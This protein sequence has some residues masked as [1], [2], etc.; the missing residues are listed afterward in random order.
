MSNETQITDEQHPVNAAEPSGGAAIPVSISFD[1]IK[2]KISNVFYGADTNTVIVTA[3]K[4]YLY[5]LTEGQ[6]ITETAREKCDSEVYRPLKN[7]YV[8]IGMTMKRSG[9]D[10][11]SA[12]SSFGIEVK[13]V[14]Y[15]SGLHKLSAIDISGLTASD[16]M[17]FS[18]SGVAV[19]G[20]GNLIAFATD[21]GLYVYNVRTSE[22]STVIDC[23]TADTGTRKGI[24]SVEQVTFMK[25]EKTLVFS[26]QSFDVPAIEGNRS[27]DTVGTVGIDGSNLVNAKVTNSRKL[28]LHGFV[29]EESK[30][31]AFGSADSGYYAVTELGSGKLYVRVYDA[32]SEKLV[33]EKE[34]KEDSRH[35]ER[36]PVVRILDKSKTLIVL[37]GNRQDDIDTIVLS[38]Q[39]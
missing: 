15:D 25:D 17:I 9:G 33:H 14:F 4:L 28:A 38:E 36:D 6:V 3:D 30:G 35:M 19:S 34:I 21:K 8:M 20:D 13:T 11:L 22:K 5:D 31:A 26:A 23:R 7:G 1:K 39:F 12:S 2:G 18:E 29:V 37:L 32:V 27:F 16:E 10:G 24:V